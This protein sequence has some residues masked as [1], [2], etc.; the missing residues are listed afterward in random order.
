MIAELIEKLRYGNLVEEKVHLKKE[1]CKAL[2]EGMKKLDITLSTWFKT[3]YN[4]D[5]LDN[6]AKRG[7]DG[8]RAWQFIIEK[9]I[10]GYL[11]QSKFIH[12]NNGYRSY[13]KISGNASPYTP[14]SFYY[15]IEVKQRG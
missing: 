11:D 4:G 9:E 12:R 2:I 1:H 6:E 3:F 15:E 8:K 7:V 14:Y 13:L 10:E 5:Y